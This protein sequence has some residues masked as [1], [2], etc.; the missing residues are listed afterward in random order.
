MT[1]TTESVASA[2]HPAILNLAALLEESGAAITLPVRLHLKNPF[3]GSS[4]YIGSESHP[5]T[6][7]LTDGTSGSLTGSLGE[8]TSE[9]E[10]GWE[11]VAIPGNSLVDN[12]FSVPVAEGCGGLF[13]FLIDPVLDAKLGLESKAPNNKAVLSGTLRSAEAQAVIASESF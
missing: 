11:A 5:V 3:L 6:L 7:H 8:P 1:A 12:T 4:C 2:A 10:R 9:V 13:A